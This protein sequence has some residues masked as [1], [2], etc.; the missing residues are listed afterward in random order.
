MFTVKVG[1]VVH[2]CEETMV[3]VTREEPAGAPGAN[4]VLLLNLRG[5]D[6]GGS[7]VIPFTVRI[8]LCW[9][10]LST[11]LYLRCISQ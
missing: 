5:G 4:R 7:S 8:K 6:G 3:P 1:R 2:L 10:E 9:Y 11:F